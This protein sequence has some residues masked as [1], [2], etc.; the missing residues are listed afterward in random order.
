MNNQAIDSK[1]SRNRLRIVK[2]NE[3][4][5]DFYTTTYGGDGGGGDMELRVAKLESDV[6][7][8]KRDISEIKDDIKDIKKD[9]KSDF[10]ML[11][12]AIIAVALGLAGLMAKG[13][14]WL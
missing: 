2:P 14:G 12:G 5:E 13:F 11:F 4:A 3:R 10:R 8:I 7:Y 6:E 1:L 9:A